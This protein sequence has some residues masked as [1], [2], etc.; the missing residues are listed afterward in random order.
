[1]KL[2]FHDALYFVVVTLFTVGYGDINPSSN[3]SWICTLLLIWIT[4]ILM[5]TQT[6]D[7]LRLMRMQSKYK[8]IDYKSTE[9]R[10]VVVTGY[11]SMQAI[12]NFCD[13]LFHDD[14]GSLSTNAV[15]IQHHDPKPEIEIFMQKY[16]NMMYYLS[17][18]P[19][20]ETDMIKRCQ[21]HKASACILLTNK[22]SSNSSEEDYRNILIALAVKKFVYD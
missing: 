5:P 21:T 17:G 10:H 6:S 8:R 14:H 1:M 3:S 12:K 15:V 2:Y 16:E 13:E 9:I 22:N 20:N 7:L 18:N 11:I 4:I 19:L